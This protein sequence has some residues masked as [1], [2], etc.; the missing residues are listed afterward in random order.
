MRRYNLPSRLAQILDSH[1]CRI[2]LHNPYL[3]P[4]M[5]EHVAWCGLQGGPIPLESEAAKLSYVLN[6]VEIPEPCGVS[7]KFDGVLWALPFTLS[8]LELHHDSSRETTIFCTLEFKRNKGFGGNSST[9]LSA[10]REDEM[11]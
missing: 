4:V 2:V 9:Y 6:G 11:A 1:K 7:H 5:K 10:Q 3:A 8:D